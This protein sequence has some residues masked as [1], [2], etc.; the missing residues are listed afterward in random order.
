MHIAQQTLE[1]HLA[2]AAEAVDWEHVVVHRCAWCAGGDN[3]YRLR[4]RVTTDGMCA[5]CASTALL[6]LAKRRLNARLAA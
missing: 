5:Q 4:P 1:A 3:V 2:A 6:R